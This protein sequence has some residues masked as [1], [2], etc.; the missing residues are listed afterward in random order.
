MFIYD[1]VTVPIASLL[2]DRLIACNAYAERHGWER[3]GEWIERNREALTSDRRPQL[4]ALIA[5]LR[6]Q[7]GRRPVVLLVGEW[8]RLSTDPQARNKWQR[9][10][11]EAGG[12]C[13]TADGDS[14]RSRLL[15]VSAARPS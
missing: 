3:K 10:V 13:E 15:D 5:M 14:D 12:W 11:R 2:I 7:A 1:R 4:E 8:D 9:Q 6:V